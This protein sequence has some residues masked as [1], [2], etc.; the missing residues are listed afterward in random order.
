MSYI[1]AGSLKNP[2][3]C[4]INYNRDNN[5]LELI[6]YENYTRKHF[7]YIKEIRVVPPYN[8]MNYAYNFILIS[9]I[10]KHK[11]VKI[12]TYLYNIYILFLVVPTLLLL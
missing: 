2:F 11:G 9:C 1:V 8:S 5:K 12:F 7:V 4:N 3:W 6:F 10:T